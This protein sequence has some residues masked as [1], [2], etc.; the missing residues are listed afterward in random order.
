MLEIKMIR[1]AL[2]VALI[3]VMA[4]PIAKHVHNAA[5]KALNF[6]VTSSTRGR[7]FVSNAKVSDRAALTQAS[8][9][10]DLARPAEP[11]GSANAA[12]LVRKPA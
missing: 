6:R 12:C 3:A 7:C 2:L 8:K 1:Y 4:N 11:P 10:C 9:L 5:S